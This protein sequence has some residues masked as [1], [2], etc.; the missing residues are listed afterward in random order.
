MTS[1]T[2]TILAP[3]GTRE[4][5]IA[6]P[7]KAIRAKCLDCSGGSA[8]EVKHCPIT[9]CPLY[10]YRLGKNPFRRQQSQEQRAAASER[11]K[12]IRNQKPPVKLQGNLSNDRLDDSGAIL[13]GDRRN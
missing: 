10:P 2:T 4:V 9:D 6:T 11:L 13:V 5:S 12:R 1:K 7:M 8:N 3:N